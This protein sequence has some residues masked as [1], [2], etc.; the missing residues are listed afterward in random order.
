MYNSNNQIKFKTSMIRSILCVWLQWYIHTYTI[1]I[2]GAGADDTA[3]NE[4][5]KEIKE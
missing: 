5:M 3:K 2:T 1:T 4:Q